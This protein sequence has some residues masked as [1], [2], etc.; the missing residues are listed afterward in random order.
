MRQLWNSV[1]C[2]V[3]LGIV[4]FCLSWPTASSACAVCGGSEAD[5]YF[6][7]VLFLMSMPFTIGSLVGGW[8]FYHYRRAAS[9]PTSATPFQ[10]HRGD[11][12]RE[13]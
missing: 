6:W 9:A 1:I 10:G 12:P 11:R 4:L 2:G 5:G 13:E 8:F 7:G 3:I